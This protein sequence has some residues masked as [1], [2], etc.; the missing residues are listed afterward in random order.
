M[1]VEN[2]KKEGRLRMMMKN[3]SRGEEKK[4]R[5]KEDEENIGGVRGK[6][7]GGMFRPSRMVLRAI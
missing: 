2:I 4:R 6:E 3:Q 7:E 1:E 5:S